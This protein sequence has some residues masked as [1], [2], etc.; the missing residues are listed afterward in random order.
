MA[1]DRR[2]PT[3]ANHGATI[4]GSDYA[5]AVNEEVE[6]LWERTTVWLDNVTGTDTLTAEADPTLLAYDRN[7]QYNLI[8]ANTNTGPATIVI[9]GLPSKSIRDID[10]VALE[11]GELVAGRLLKLQDDGT[12]LRIMNRPP[13][14]ASTS[15]A[16]VATQIFTS[17]G[18]YTPNALLIFARIQVQAPGGGGGGGDS[19]NAGPQKNGGGGGGGEYAEGFFDAATIGASQSVTIGSQGAAGSNTGGNGGAGSTTSVGSLITAAPG[20]GGTGTGSNSSSGANRAGGAGGTGGTGGHLRIP[21]AAG[22]SGIGFTPDAGSNY[23]N[24]RGKG[25]DSHLSNPD[26]PAGILTAGSG[27]VTAGI[28]GSNYGG[29]GSGGASESNTGAVGGTGGASIVII[30]EYL[31]AP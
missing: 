6:A 23:F 5:N 15:V 14:Q 8:P 19:N 28:N 16:S 20:A 10:G 29:G 26:N 4:D 13:E 11:G 24:W 18:T 7:N 31:R 22:S 2:T 25:G 30:T 17:T 27:T 1:V 9:D 12:N 3:T 21:G